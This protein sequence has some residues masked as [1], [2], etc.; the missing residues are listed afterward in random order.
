MKC[1]IFLRR[2]DVSL[3]VLR[4]FGP[5]KRIARFVVA[6]DET[7]EQFFQVLPGMLNT[8]DKALLAYRIASRQGRS[9]AVPAAVNAFQ[10]DAEPK[11]GFDTGTRSVTA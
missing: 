5:G 7:V 2:L 11:L 9:S 8:L 1:L 10:M 3:Q 4:S 6:G